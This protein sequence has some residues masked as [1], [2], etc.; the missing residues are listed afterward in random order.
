[1]NFSSLRPM[2]RDTER[3]RPSEAQEAR[4]SP[5]TDARRQGN[6]SIFERVRSE[7]GSAVEEG[8]QREPNP[9]QMVQA[10]GRARRPD[11]PAQP[12]QQ[13][14]PGQQAGPALGPVPGPAPAPLT[15]AER[16]E[17]PAI[18]E[19]PTTTAATVQARYTNNP[20]AVTAMNEVTGDATFRR[21]TPAQQGGLLARF[22][23]APNRATS[24]YVRGMAAYHAAAPENR[25]AGLDAFRSAR[26]PDGG[27]IT[28]NGNTYSVQNG[29]LRNEA[30]APAGNVHTDGT[31]QLTGEAGRRNYYDEEN[32]RVRLTEGE[33][34]Q[35]QTLTDLH[36]ADPGN[37]LGGAN[38]NGQFRDRAR[39]TLR[40]MRREGV[41]M[42][43][44]DGYRDYNE[45]DRLYAQGRTA[46]GPRVTNARGGH[47]WHNY[48]VA[49]DSTFHDNRGQPHWPE[50]GE[51]RSLLQRYGE[52]G[53]ARGLEWGGRWT[54]PVDTPHQQYVPN[55]GRPGAQEET[56]RNQ[57]LPQ[58]WR[59]MGIGE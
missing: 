2:A 31:Y 59:N 7:V 34:A 23:E 44:T 14:A 12:A 46:P 6:G 53:E 51:H 58:V 10:Q 54:N 30:G 3:R 32:T 15:D 19:N 42:M 37:R 36:R 50:G 28:A 39:G 56:L 20:R 5:S 29:Q 49:M 13:G 38:V 24:Q 41:S 27:T 43:V 9:I 18:A 45:Q 48:G 35:Q 57:G 26:D 25:R 55:G 40:D 11:G 16:A 22:Q 52:V 8:L 17:V 4:P 21:L 47:S 1:M 33:G